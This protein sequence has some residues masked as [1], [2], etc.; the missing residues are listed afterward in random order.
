MD[1]SYSFIYLF[2]TLEALYR[3]PISRS[4]MLG[5]LARV[6]DL[7]EGRLRGSDAMRVSKDITGMQRIF[8]PYIS[9]RTQ[10]DHTATDGAGAWVSYDS[11][12]SN[13]TELMNIS[14]ISSTIS[15]ILSISCVRVSYVFHIYFPIFDF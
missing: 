15:L 11:L 5:E 6:I 7:Q 2:R 13:L 12:A 1:L 9:V 14:D 10:D 4:K 8:T 3:D